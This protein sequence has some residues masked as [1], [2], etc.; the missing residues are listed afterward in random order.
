MSV[1]SNDQPNAAEVRIQETLTAPNPGDFVTA[2]N[3]GDPVIVPN[4]GDSVTAPKGPA[5]GVP[6][7]SEDVYYEFGEATTLPKQRRRKQGGRRGG[8][9][10]LLQT[11]VR[12]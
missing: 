4:L 2:Q 11:A 6:Q 1:P 10:P 3:P 8:S 7:P 5:V 12:C 9:E